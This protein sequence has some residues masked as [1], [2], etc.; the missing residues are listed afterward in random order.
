MDT[1]DIKKQIN[2]IEDEIFNTQKN[3]ATE[4]HIGKLKAKLARLREELEKHKSSGSKGA[5]FT[6]K[7]QGDATIAL[8]GFPSIG[9]STLLNQITS[10]DSEV[11]SYDFTTLDV[12]P[13]MMKY[14]GASI[15]IF[16]LPG[17][18][19]G[20]HKGKGRGREIISAVRNADLVLFMIDAQHRDHLDLMAAELYRSGLRLNQKRPDV[21]INKKGEGGITVASPINLSHLDEKIIRSIASE[22]LVNADIVIREDITEDQL[23]DVLIGNRSYIPALV[24]IN[25]ID[26]IEREELSKKMKYISDSGW[27]VISISA[28]KNIGLDKLQEKIFSK[29]KLIRVYM[30]PV[31]KK[32]D[33]KEPLILKKGDTIEDACKKLHR[34]FKRKFRYAYVTGPS[35][36]HDMQKAGLDHILKDE[37]IL[38]IVVSK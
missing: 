26:L 30:K 13:G 31:G 29:L 18:I 28:S 9:K 14:K 3:K 10:A 12:I 36:K 5:G 33:F 1:T 8:I 22:Y 34:D 27:D 38:T 11:G 2:D 15:Q 19:S 6:I 16:D 23:I 37:D 25:K 17:L 24:V 21:V 32:A 35:A 7:K 4:H 20:A